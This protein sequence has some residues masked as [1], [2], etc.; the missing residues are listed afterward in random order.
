MIGSRRDLRRAGSSDDSNSRSLRALPL[1]I[2]VAPAN[3]SPRV[4]HS[5]TAQRHP[6]DARQTAAAVG[7]VERRRAV[8]VGLKNVGHMARTQD[9][10]ISRRRLRSREPIPVLHQPKIAHRMT[11][12]ADAHPAA[13]ELRLCTAFGM[14]HHLGSRARCRDMADMRGNLSYRFERPHRAPVRAVRFMRRFT[15]R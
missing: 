6:M 3:G 13:A 8:P 5:P 9:G 2:L 12:N 1:R 14:R 11:E 10:D 7:I 4:N 15:G